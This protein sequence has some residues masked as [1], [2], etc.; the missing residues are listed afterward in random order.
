MTSQLSQAPTNNREELIDWWNA[1]TLK[2]KTE[3]IEDPLFKQSGVMG[4]LFIGQVCT[5]I[6]DAAFVPKGILFVPG[7]SNIGE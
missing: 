5:D 2:E 6:D 4:A 7:N 3:V 1:L